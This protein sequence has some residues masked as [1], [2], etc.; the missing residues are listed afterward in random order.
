MICFFGNSLLCRNPPHAKVA[1]SSITIAHL[2][3][4]TMA[5]AKRVLRYFDLAGPAERK[6]ILRGLVD[7]IQYDEF[8]LLVKARHKARHKHDVFGHNRMP[9]EIRLM[10]V[11]YL[12]ITDI[13]NCALLVCHKWRDLFM[14]S[15]A[16]AQDVLQTWFP[17]LYQRTMPVRDMM[18]SFA[19]IIMKRYLRDTGRFQTR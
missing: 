19:Q 7:R 15:E 4:D 17:C 3:S 16:M 1:V 8:E 13:Y 5:S 2:S 14:K 12:D 6:D 9:L 18:E 10:I 11:Q